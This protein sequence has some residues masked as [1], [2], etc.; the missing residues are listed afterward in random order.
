M[1]FS[2]FPRL[3]LLH[4]GLIYLGLIAYAVYQARAWR[5]RNP[6]LREIAPLFWL[7]CLANI[8]WLF[9]WHYNQISLTVLAMLVILATLI[10]IYLKLDIGRARV[11]FSE[12]LLVHVPFSIYLGWITVATVA[13]LTTALFALGWNGA[14]FGPEAWA[15]VVLVVGAA[16]TAA[17]IETRRDLAY[18]LVIVWAYVGVAVK[19][20]G[21]P[22][23]ST[24]RWR[25]PPSVARA[26]RSKPDP[27]ARPSESGVD[28][29]WEEARGMPKISIGAYVAWQYAAGEAVSAGYPVIEARHLFLG[30]L[31]L[32]K[33]FAGS[34]DVEMNWN[35]LEALRQET[36]LVSPGSHRPWPR[37]GG[38]SAGLP[39]TDR[40]GEPRPVRVGG[41][42]QQQMPSYL[43]SC[44]GARWPG[45]ADDR[46]SPARDRRRGYSGQHGHLLREVGILSGELA[47]LAHA[48]AESIGSQ[49]ARAR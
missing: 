40:P 35:E 23:V 48:V 18:L 3:C 29:G 38:A 42:P 10:A 21:V 34:D 49:R 30:V 16:I 27:S 2:S 13:N 41:P 44:P 1:P 24:S 14:P 33:A 15:V 39:P 17:V 43:R 20:S 12:K 11:S 22:V 37:A 36:D 46:N 7:S 47:D 31:S 6:R 25:W 32:E 19:Q 5:A 28:W 26:G 4:W 9:L 8:V 45:Q